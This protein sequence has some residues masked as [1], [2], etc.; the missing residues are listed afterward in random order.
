MTATN[1]ASLNEDPRV[2]DAARGYLAELEAGRVP[3]RLAYVSRHP[4]LAGALLA[5]FDGI[6]LAHAAAA[7]L[8]PVAAPS[9]D[10]LPFSVR[11]SSGL[12][13]W[14]FSPFGSEEID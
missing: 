1:T 7:V 11:E 2:L 13:L 10:P 12:P 9:P 14:L 6:D 3:D 8:E 4:E 5:C